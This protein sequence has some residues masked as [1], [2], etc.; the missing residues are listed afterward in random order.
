MPRKKNV[1]GLDRTRNFTTIV[2]PDSA[3]A[4]WLSILGDQHVPAFV[5]PL[6][7]RDLNPDG[8][9]K[10]PHWH[11]LIMFDSVKTMKQAKELF[12]LIGGVGCQKVNSMRGNSRYLCHLD[13]PEKAQYDVG[14]VK[15]FAG[16]DYHEICSLVSDRY[17]AI[18]DMLEFCE[19]YDII[20]FA[21][22]LVYCSENR[23]DWFKIL[24]DGGSF[25]LKEY[26]KSRNWGR[27][28]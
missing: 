8:E 16:A 18:R 22:F 25:V 15:A 6:H 5:S 28:G 11:V 21:D 27:E 10:K 4:D 26:M 3:P 19:C 23:F 9:L 2:Y 20:S 14:E 17:V 12:D 24:C 7:N 13:N 1:S